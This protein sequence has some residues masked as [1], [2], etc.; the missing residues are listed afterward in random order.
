MP[1]GG[2]SASRLLAGK[3]KGH[4]AIMVEMPFSSVIHICS[5]RRTIL[6]R[7]GCP[8]RHLAGVSLWAMPSAMSMDGKP[9]SL[10]VS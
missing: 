9:M 5:T 2:A 3:W 1:N 8:I 4:F 10:S 6:G 7:Y